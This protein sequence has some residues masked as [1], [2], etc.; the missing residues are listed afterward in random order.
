MGRPLQLSLIQL[1]LGVDFYSFK[2]HCRARVSSQTVLAQ[3]SIGREGTTGING[4][5]CI[6]AN[7]TNVYYLVPRGH[8]RHSILMAY[9][10][11]YP[12]LPP[13][14]LWPISGVSLPD[15]SRAQYVELGQ[16][17]NYSQYGVWKQLQ[18]FGCQEVFIV[19][20]QGISCQLTSVL[21]SV[22]GQSNLHV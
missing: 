1:P 18:Y 9:R 16:P 2:I 3:I 17:T 12:D 13:A 11:G 7:G 6:L 14:A 22:P 10:A 4:Y 15:N 21:K 8:P 19:W 20:I 5:I